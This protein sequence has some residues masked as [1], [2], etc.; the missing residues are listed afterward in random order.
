MRAKREYIHVLWRLYKNISDCCLWDL[1]IYNMI[2]L[3]KSWKYKV[4]K[5][6]KCMIFR[7]VSCTE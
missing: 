4:I 6:A 3:N 1:H 2:V 7:I 5:T